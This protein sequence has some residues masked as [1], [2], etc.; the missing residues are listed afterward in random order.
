MCVATG[1]GARCDLEIKK[2]RNQRYECSI[3]FPGYECSIAFPVSLLPVVWGVF[4]S[5]MS[6]VSSLAPTYKRPTYKRER[7]GGRFARSDL[8]GGRVISADESTINCN[9]FQYQTCRT[10]LCLRYW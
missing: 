10:V 2:S 3:A 9:Q 8:Q 6:E 5:N 7:V 4:W 1:R